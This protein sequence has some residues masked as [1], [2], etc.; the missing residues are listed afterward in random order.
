[1]DRLVP[2]VFAFLSVTLWALAPATG[3]TPIDTAW[4]QLPQYAYG[5]DLGP[6]LAIERAVIEAMGSPAVRAGTAHRLAA[7]LLQPQTTPAAKQFI[8]LQLRQIGTP[9]EIPILAPLL[10][11][12]ESS[13]MARC[14]IAA[15][16]G[17]ES[18]DALRYAARYVAGRIVGR[19][20][21]CTGR[22][23]RR[24][25]CREVDGIGRVRQT[26]RCDR[27][28]CAV[29][30]R[31]ADPSAVEYLRGLA[32]KQ[33]A[34]LPTELAGG[35]LQVAS[36]L[37]ENGHARGGVGN[38][39]RPLRARGAAWNAASC[40]GGTIDARN[41]GPPCRNVARLVHGRR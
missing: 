13:E 31:I 9:A 4:E 35:L 2:C 38:L 23:T 25:L 22:T 41:I 19:S 15:I 24:R 3:Q 5:Q 30:A 6:L 14:A 12:P 32:A 27:R 28:P 34:P 20:D 18:T 8:C 16:P 36:V 11:A 37:V 33:P 21:Q 29:L 17:P 26:S 7:L 40:L 10:L 1:M 39:R